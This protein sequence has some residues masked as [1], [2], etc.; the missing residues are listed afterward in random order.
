[1][2]ERKS[3]LVNGYRDSKADAIALVAERFGLPVAR[4]VSL[5]KEQGLGDDYSTNVSELSGEVLRQGR[6]PVTVR[7]KS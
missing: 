4:V 5:A 6:V 2:T 7:K 1:M 3:N